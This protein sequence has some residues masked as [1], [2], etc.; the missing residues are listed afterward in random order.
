LFGGLTFNFAGA[1]PPKPPPVLAYATDQNEKASV[2]Q[3]T[4]VRNV[5]V[6]DG[7]LPCGNNFKQPSVKVYRVFFTASVDRRAIKKLIVKAAGGPDGIPPAFLINCIDELSYSLSLL[8]AFS[9]KLDILPAIRLTSLVSPLFTKGNPAD[10][11]NYRPLALTVCMCKLVETVIKDQIVHF[12]ADKGLV[13]KGQ[14]VFIELLTSWQ[15]CTIGALAS[16][17][18]YTA[19]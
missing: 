10:A 14:H 3:H 8:Y 1:K 5:T 16:A 6:D 15:A 4:F 9:F 7:P 11:N 17:S 13:S 2:L 19:I 18:I 12:L